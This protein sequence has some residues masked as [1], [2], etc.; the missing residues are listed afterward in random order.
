[1][2]QRSGPCEPWCPRSVTSEAVASSFAFVG[3]SEAFQKVEL[4]ARVTGFLNER[5]F[6]EGEQVT[7]DEQM[8]VID[9]SEYVANRDAA[10]AKVAGSQATLSE[11]VLNLERY[12][13]L[14]EKGTASQAKYDE[15]VAKE[16][17]AR[18][19]L[20]A[21]K[22]DLKRAELDVGYTKITSPIEGRVGSASVDVGNLIGPDSG[23]LATVVTLAPIHVAFS[24]SEREYLNFRQAMKE[25]KQGEVKP[26]I[27]LAND[28]VYPHDGTLD[29]DI[30]ATE[31]GAEFGR[32]IEYYTG[33]VFQIELPELRRAGQIA[34]GGRYDG[35]LS[36]LGSPERVP[37]VGCAIHTERLLMAA[38]GGD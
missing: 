3:Q 32:V 22:A 5:A 4:R 12:R 38:G 26:R 25:G 29:I 33:Y 28:K 23:V 34:G 31:F 37:A 8:F 6:V 27:Q 9:P 11:A 17:Q 36:E 10:K 18:A 16:G 14:L 21:A 19:D 30:N 35:L 13:K 20:E 2:P 1:M 24:I 7:R 15:A